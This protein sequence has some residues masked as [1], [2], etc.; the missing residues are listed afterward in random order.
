MK[1]LL[2]AL[3]I[4]SLYY[5]CQP[6]E[7][8]DL[9]E[10]AQENSH[11]ATFGNLEQGDIL[12]Y[13]FFYGHSYYTDVA[14]RC[15]TKDTLLIEVTEVV[16]DNE[17]IVKEY[18]SQNSEIFQYLPDSNYM[19][20]NPT[21]ELSYNW[22]IQNDTLIIS[23]ID[24][25]GQSWLNSKL[26]YFNKPYPLNN[27]ALVP[28]NFEKWKP[29]PLDG[30][31]CNEIEILGSTYT[32]LHL[33]VENGPTDADGNGASYL[34]NNEYGFVRTFTNSAWTGDIQGW[35]LIQ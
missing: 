3:V 12:E 15:Y 27:D 10:Q 24:D 30:N 6:S 9:S 33:Y 1:Q 5:A 20:F 35:D 26:T 34:Y 16:S 32:D 18:L 17:L 11:V 14:E 13:R 23:S 29:Q 22:S 28:V 31:F 25:P 8:C 19:W 21:E 4:C 2:L 7:C